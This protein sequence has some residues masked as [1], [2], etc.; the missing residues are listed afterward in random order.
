MAGDSGSEQ[1]AEKVRAALRQAGEEEARRRMAGPEPIPE[2][3]PEESPQPEPRGPDAAHGDDWERVYPSKGARS[4]KDER[5]RADTRKVRVEQGSSHKFRLTTPA[6]ILLAVVV[7]YPLLGVIGLMLQSATTPKEF[8]FQVGD[9]LVNKN[10]GSCCMMVLRTEENHRFM[11]GTVGRAYIVNP[12]LSTDVEWD[13]VA[14]VLEQLAEVQRSDSKLVEIPTKSFSPGAQSVRSTAGA[15][16]WAEQ[17]RATESSARA[18]EA[19]KNK[20]VG[21]RAAR[22]MQEFPGGL[23]VIMDGNLWSSYS[24]GRKQEVADLILEAALSG[25]R[26]I[27]IPITV[28]AAEQTERGDD[29][30]TLPR[31]AVSVNTPPMRMVILQ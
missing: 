20:I 9:R 24:D 8:K 1:F 31:L 6:K 13:M 3:G 25:N 27:A 14:D 16:D 18:L 21:L 5:I 17:Q 30:F 10:N 26:R 29:Y 15:P 2:H 19:V 4:E 23:F 11:N 22:P 12:A 7:G 28:V